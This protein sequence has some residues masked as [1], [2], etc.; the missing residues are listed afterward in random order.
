MVI[1]TDKNGASTVYDGAA[2]GHVNP[3]GVL[4]IAHPFIGV[5]SAYP[6]GEWL[7]MMNAAD[8]EGDDNLF[9]DDEDESAAPTVN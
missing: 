3:V 4:I 5:V 2:T 9:D 1:V 7:R 8:P 6:P